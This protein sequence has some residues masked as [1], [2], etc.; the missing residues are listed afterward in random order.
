MRARLRQITRY[1]YPLLSE[2]N[3]VTLAYTCFADSS[4]ARE[5]DI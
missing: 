5:L 2:N 4:T 3:I 1:P